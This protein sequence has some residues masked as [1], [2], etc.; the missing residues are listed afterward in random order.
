MPIELPVAHSMLKT[1]D[2]ESTLGHSLPQARI[3]IA[4]DVP[5]VLQLLRDSLTGLGYEVMTATTGIEAIDAVPG[6]RPDVILVDMKMPGLSGIKVLDALRRA[7][8]T[9]PVILISV[10]PPKARDG[11]FATIKKPFDLD[12][13][14]RAVADAVR[15]L[16]LT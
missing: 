5:E 10:Q 9:V 13:V 3:L 8:L 14:S 12:T 6:F 4:D 1:S 16:R 15:Q 11:F 2:D 7:G